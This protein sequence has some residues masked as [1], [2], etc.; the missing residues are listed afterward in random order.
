M[1]AKRRET[2]SELLPVGGLLAVFAL[3]RVLYGFAGVRFDL[4]PLSTYWQYLDPVLLRTDLWRSLWSLHSQPPLYNLFIGLV[5]GLSDAPGPVF[6][7]AGTAL[8]VLVVA[9]LYLLARRLG[10]ARAPALAL[11]G[12]YAVSPTL[13]LYENWLHYTLPVSALLLGTV[14]AAERVAETGRRRWA[15]ALGTALAGLCLTMSFFHALF[16]VPAGLAAILGARGTSQASRAGRRAAIATGAALVFVL[17]WY[18]KN[19][20]RF[21]AFS[22]SSWFGMNLARM[23]H[24]FVPRPDR[25]ALVREGRISPLALVAPFSAPDAYTAFLPARSVTPTGIPALDEEKRSGGATNFNHIGYVAVSRAYLSDARRLL[26]LRPA[27]YRRSVLDANL[28]FFM[29]ATAFLGLGENRVNARTAVLAEELLQGRLMFHVEPEL[30]RTDL[31]T[32]YR[33]KA[34]NMGLALPLLYAVALAAAAF[35]CLRLRR[36]EPARAAVFGLIVFALVYVWAAGTLLEVGENMRF[37]SMVD[38]LVL[39]VLAVLA[40]SRRTG[41]SA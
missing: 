11:A 9:M 6:A 23:T 40:G 34:L 17:A 28:I 26:R 13:V 7:A 16:I 1:K 20:A 24:T 3:A 2:K 15:A 12:L 10:A 31:P 29:P 21:G 35:L 4:T 38:P 14:F 8:G 41:R 19:L 25:E 33:Q 32:F 36:R 18:G 30:Q 39:V 5:L 22:A 37:R 27:A